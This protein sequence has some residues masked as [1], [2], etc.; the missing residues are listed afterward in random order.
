MENTST[1][2]ITSRRR[3]LPATAIVIVLASLVATGVMYRENRRL[4]ADP[5]AV[6]REEAVRLVQEVGALIELPQGEVPTIAT[7]SDV[8]RLKEQPFFAKAKVGDK[9]LIFTNAR[10]AILFSAT[11]RKILEVAPLNIGNAATPPTKPSASP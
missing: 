7:V 8:E 11:S 2:T 10:K 9:V 5:G 3:I 4:K 6:A 1:R